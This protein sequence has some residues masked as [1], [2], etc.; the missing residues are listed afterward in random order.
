M[1]V[2]QT[3]KFTRG[4]YAHDTWHDRFLAEIHDHFNIL[5]G[6][7]CVRCLPPLALHLSQQPPY[8]SRKRSTLWAA[9][10]ARMFSPRTGDSILQDGV[11]A[12]L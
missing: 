9:T 2:A 11:T 7:E 6:A 8:N 5:P 10:F 1:T 3:V 12:F 4:F